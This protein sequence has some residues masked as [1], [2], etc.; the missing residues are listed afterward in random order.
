MLGFYDHLKPADAFP[1]AENAALKA[2]AL[3]ARLAA[4]HATI[5]YVN[6]YY[7]WNWSVAEE[8]FRRAIAIE[9]TYSTAHQW[10]SNFL[11]AMGRFDEAER[12]MRVAQEL[13][14]LSLI[15]N[16]ALG[17]VFVHAG[18]HD[19]AVAQCKRTIA[20]D[21][22]FQLA[23]MWMGIAG[24]YLGRHTEAV[25]ATRESVRLS[26]GSA[27]QLSAHAFTLAR[28][29]ARDSAQATLDLLHTRERAGQYIPSYELAKAHL[30][31]GDTTASLLRLERAFDERAHSMALLRVDPQ[32]A[33][34]RDKPRYRALLRKVGLD[35]QGT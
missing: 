19:Q 25:R 7:R 15:A 8:S 5:G 13:D 24:S 20:L 35:K 6:L 21:P 9:P 17:W 23:H 1:R 2:L 14:P 26:G 31:L 12:E 27:L 22:N 3:D 4:P 16:A 34:L 28:S 33:G 18:R 10:L 29:G 30:A 32:L 11:T